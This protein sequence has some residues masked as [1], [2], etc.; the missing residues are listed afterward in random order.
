MAADT[1]IM[2]YR[3]CTA[4][5]VP[6]MQDQKLLMQR[7]LGFLGGGSD[8]VAA[9]FGDK[10]GQHFDHGLIS[11]HRCLIIHDTG[12]KIVDTALTLILRR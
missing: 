3:Q 10:G 7:W 9:I 2:G 8:S 4:L 1:L 6:M 5:W 11:S 12:T